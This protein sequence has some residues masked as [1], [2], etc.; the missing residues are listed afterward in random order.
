MKTNCSYLFGWM[1]IMTNIK[2]SSKMVN[3]KYLTGNREEESKLSALSEIFLQS[4]LIV[5]N[6]KQSPA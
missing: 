3:P 1:E 4:T 2:F 6:M 5:I